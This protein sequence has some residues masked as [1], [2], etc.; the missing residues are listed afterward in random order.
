MITYK[1]YKEKALKNPNFKREYDKLRPEYEFVV[2]MTRERIAKRMTQQALAQKLHT[3][4]SAISRL[5]SGMYNPSLKFLKD[6]AK[7]LDCKLNIS[8]NPA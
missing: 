3:K 8:F 4:Q 7:A 2:S 1:E 6:V 5:E